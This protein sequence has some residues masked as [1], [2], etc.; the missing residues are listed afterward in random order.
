MRGCDKLLGLGL[1]LEL[2]VRV[3]VRVK[4][5]D[6]LVGLSAWIGRDVVK[7]ETLSIKMNINHQEGRVGTVRLGLCVYVYMPAVFNSATCAGYVILL[8]ENL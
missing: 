4:G 2:G 1:G 7:I 5:C 3:R 6:K 8:F